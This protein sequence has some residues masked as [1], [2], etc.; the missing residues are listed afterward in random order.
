MRADGQGGLRARVADYLG[1]HHVMSIATASSGGNVPHAANVFYVVDDKMRLIFLSQKSSL[2][3]QDI[4][5]EAPVSVTVSEQ[6]E[7]W[8]EIQGVQLW[9]KARLLSGAAK[10]GALARYTA[11]F[12]FVR[13]LL[14]EPRLAARLKDVGVYIVEADRAGFT[15]NTSELFDRQTLELVRD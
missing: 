6:Y 11:R 5:R 14:A 13:D 12:P 9:G 3:G 8:H 4:G 15:D 2:H 7:D 10:A 1:A